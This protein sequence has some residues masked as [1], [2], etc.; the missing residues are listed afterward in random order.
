MWAECANTSTEQENVYVT[1][2]KT[3]SAEE[4]F[5]DKEVPGW[6]HM[7]QFGKIGIVNYGSENKHKAKHLNRGR[8]CMYL[9]LAKDRPKDTFRFLNLETH[10]VIMSHDVIWMDAVYGDYKKMP[11]SDIARIIE[12]DDDDDSNTEVRRN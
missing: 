2:N 9:G 6:Q 4:Q 11:E 8:A 10:K 5:Y 12:V 1:K 3:I 7:K